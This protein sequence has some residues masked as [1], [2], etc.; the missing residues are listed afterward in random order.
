MFDSSVKY[1]DFELVYIEPRNSTITY[2]ASHAITPSLFA[3][4]LN[5]SACKPS[6]FDYKDGGTCQYNKPAWYR[7]VSNV[8][9]SLEKY[10]T[11]CVQLEF[12]R[13]PIPSILQSFLPAIM[14]V[15]SSWIGFFIDHK[16]VPARVFIP[17]TLFLAVGRI[18]TEFG[19]A[20]AEGIYQ[21]SCYVFVFASLVEFGIV[22]CIARR[23]N[24]SPV[25][26]QKNRCRELANSVMSTACCLGEDERINPASSIRMEKSDVAKREGELK[27]VDSEMTT[28]QRLL[29]TTT[30]SVNS[31]HHYGA[32]ERLD[33]GDSTSQ[34]R[35]L[36]GK[37]V[38]ESWCTMF[39][40]GDECAHK[41]DVVA[42]VLF[43]VI[44][45]LFNLV[46][47]TVCMK[48]IWDLRPFWRAT[49]RL[50]WCRTL[51]QS[52]CRRSCAVS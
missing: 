41:A 39:P 3:I 36:D 9:I 1:K 47:W 29:S 21:L 19:H 25:K 48:S 14:L 52:V 26:K 2:F 17:T 32:A 15:I 18:K 44:F 38:V 10:S 11:F 27:P 49:L 34:T 43:P 45:V 4:Q 5:N 20:T 24:S 31:R 37:G 8:C 42:R 23:S 51:Y 50:D 30:G 6:T 28:T 12:I 46:F 16:A 13:D 40:H 35:L 33:T 22:H 7:G